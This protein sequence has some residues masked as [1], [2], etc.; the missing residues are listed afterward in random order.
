[1]RTLIAAFIVGSACAG[2]SA[3]D[4]KAPAAPA[5]STAA[6]AGVQAST[7]PARAQ[8]VDDLYGGAKFR[9]P[10]SP[11]SG[12]GGGG[13]MTAETQEFTLE[14]FSIQ[15]LELRG[16]MKDRR[17]SFAVL[18]DIDSRTGF[19]LRN[20]KLYDYK[21]KQIPGVKGQI[22]LPQK[23]VTLTTEDK[24]TRTFRLGEEKEA[25]E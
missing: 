22:S 16:I 24:D 11:V 4:P 3:A 1:M 9:D 23:S 21:K 20:G 17:G 8:T 7:T 5:V 25:E 6:A 15:N 13:R 2:A 14:D 10:F 18:L 19:I 12:S